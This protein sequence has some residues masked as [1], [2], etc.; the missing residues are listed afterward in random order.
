MQNNPFDVGTGD[1][2]IVTDAE[3]SSPSI[4]PDIVTPA[5]QAVQIDTT[6]PFPFPSNA[7][8]S[9]EIYG[10]TY[11]IN[12]RHLLVCPTDW[13]NSADNGV[14]DQAIESADSWITAVYQAFVDA[15][16]RFEVLKV[17]NE[18]EAASFRKQA[19]YA[20]VEAAKKEVTDKVV[21][22]Y[23]APTVDDIESMKLRMFGDRL[24][25]MRTE[26]STTE[27]EMM[28][29]N[30]L[31]WTLSKRSEKLNAISDRLHSDKLRR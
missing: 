18:R 29:L 30:N 13:L 17:R 5:G 8:L 19:V 22:K 7:K 2:F 3:P 16:V 4:T 31:H 11:S 27:A 28:A 25:Q 20:A 21:D 14:L 26:E 15:K 6:G 1:E 23:K 9:F 24:I 10:R 12:P